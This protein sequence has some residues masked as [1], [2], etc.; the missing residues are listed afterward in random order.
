LTPSGDVAVSFS[1]GLDTTLAVTLLLERFERVHLNVYCNGY[2]LRVH[3]AHPRVEK[4][5]DLYGAERV[6]CN[7]MAVRS[8][9]DGILPDYAGDLDRIGSPLLFDLCCRFAMEIRTIVYCLER[10]ISHAADGLNCAQPLIF[11]LEPDY[12]ALA[13]QFMAEYKIEFLHPVY[14]SG[15]RPERRAALES[16]G[17]N[18]EVRPLTMLQ[19]LG[20]MPQISEQIMNQPLCY[21]QGPIF[22]LTSPLRNMPVLRRFGL[23]VPRAQAYRREREVLA[24]EVIARQLREQGVDIAKLLDQ[25]ATPTSARQHFP[26]AM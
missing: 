13:D 21:A 22:L 26:D 18:D 12:I 15:E 5:Q 25:R 23:P 4:L 11:L 19:K 9:L 20:L 24:R 1:G 2:C 16:Q 3:S 6:V 7:T 10:G 14:N 17:L 8:E